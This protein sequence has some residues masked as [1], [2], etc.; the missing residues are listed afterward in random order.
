MISAI[1]SI[2]LLRKALKTETFRDTGAVF[3]GNGVSAILGA[4]FFFLLARSLG[5]FGFGTFSIALAISTIAVDLFDIAINNALVAYGSTPENRCSAFRSGLRK[6]VWLTALFSIGLWIV[7]PLVLFILGKPEMVDIV[8]LSILIVPARAA[9]SFVKTML[10]TLRRFRLD[11]G[12]DIA[13]A[14]LRL[15]LFLAAVSLRLPVLESSIV[16][17]ALSMVVAIVPAIPLC[18]SVLRISDRGH[19][20]LGFSRFQS[21]M[22][23]SFVASA[24]SARL[25]VFALTRFVGVDAVGLYQAAFRLFLPIQQLASALSRVFA[26]RLASFSKESDARRYL[27]KSLALS[28]GL[29]L[30]MLLAIPFFPWAIPLLYGR[31]FQP[32]VPYAAGLTVNF[33]IFLFSVPWWTVLLYHRKDARLFAT[34]SIVGL[35]LTATGIAILTKPFGV[36]GVIVAQ[37]VAGGVLTVVVSRKGTI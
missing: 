36:W 35:T 14:A 29:T 19:T 32:S 18:F 16:A 34:L 3:V 24:I 26:P 31:A 9:S 23:V 10:Q 12:L 8:R 4:I 37:I 21:W 5:P 28:G 11:A 7:A 20:N 17:Y 1:S 33:M 22:T 15:G 6:K 25:D 13:A 27:R 30:S 2:S